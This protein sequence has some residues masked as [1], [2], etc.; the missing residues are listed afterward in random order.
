M[1]PRNIC[2]EYILKAIDEI[3]VKG[4][5]KGRKPKKFYLWYKGKDYPPKYV[6]SLANMFANGTE[7]SPSLFSGGKE[8]NGFL[9]G[10]GFQVGRKNEAS[11][12]IQAKMPVIKRQTKHNERCGECKNS[13]IE[14]FRRLYGEVKVD[15]KVKVSARLQ[16]YVRQPCYATLKRIISALQN[17]RGYK[18]IVKAKY[19]SRCDLF[20][21][22]LNAI[23]EFDESQHFTSARKLTLSL[24]P[25]ELSLGFDLSTWEK[26]CDIIDAKDNDPEYRDEQRA[27]YDT[28]RD[29]LPL[30]SKMN[31]TIRIHMGDFEWCSLNPHDPKDVE[32]FRDNLMSILPHGEILGSKTS[33]K[34][35]VATVT[36]RSRGKYTNASRAELM[37]KVLQKI[38]SSVDAVVFP[39]GFYRTRGRPST[40]ID[41]FVQHCESLVRSTSNDIMV[42]CFGIDG[43]S[44]KDQIAVAVGSN[45]I[46]GAGRKFHPTT[47]EAGWAETANSA[48]AKEMG[49]PRVFEVKSKRIFLAVCYDGFGIRH[50]GLMNPGVDIVF[51][52]VH[53]FYPPGEGGS[54]DP[55]FAKHGFAGASKQWGCAT[56]G[57]A[58]FFKRHIPPNWPTGVMWNQG[59][60]STQRWRYSENPLKPYREFQVSCK[61]EKTL[62]RLFKI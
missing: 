6:V 8:V 12:R 60:K 59:N 2:R 31:P 27:W 7:L 4:V 49:Y 9:T 22:G 28:L 46:L 29:F 43:R 47:E 54:G 45:G 36:I 58:V 61:T 16:D 35:N 30:L 55:Y 25:S 11:R 34:L 37:A 17:H 20:I 10:L 51:D 1:I 18:D 5:P 14:M 40:Q 32:V 15:H 42:V 33:T 38:G 53:A 50:K 21:P 26:L 3:E 24:Y 44:T 56:F 57:A 48:D 39:A 23:V 52:L 41:G 62:I 19:L 13:I